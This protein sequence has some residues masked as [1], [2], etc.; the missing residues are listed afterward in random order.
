M[1]NYQ[2]SWDYMLD[3][4]VEV[5]HLSLLKRL[6]KD[7]KGNTLPLFKAFKSFEVYQ[8]IL[9]DKILGV[10]CLGT[11]ARPIIGVDIGNILVACEEYNNIPF[12]LALK[13]TILHELKHAWQEWNDLEMDED[14]AEKFAQAY[15]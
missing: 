10:Y 5:K 4:Y 2:I 6:I 9:P 3:E 13:T 11:S 8:I 1:H 12:E 15:A 7:I 14:E